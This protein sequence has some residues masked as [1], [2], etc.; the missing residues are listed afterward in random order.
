MHGKWTAEKFEEHHKNHPD[1]Y[2]MFCHYAKKAA[3]A[4]KHYSA[5]CVFHRVRWE[6][7]IVEKNSDF[8]IDDGWI[9][10]YARKFMEDH[11]EHD[12]F[13]ETRER[14]ESYHHKHSKDWKD[15]MTQDQGLDV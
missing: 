8:K 9:S 2:R 15:E 10:H 4:R 7:Q 14:R 6:T 5:K 13:F 12:G 3:A 11:P 1:K